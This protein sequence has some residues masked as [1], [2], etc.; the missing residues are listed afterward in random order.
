MERLRGG[1]GI[2]RGVEAAVWESSLRRK[3]G[4]C[5]DDGEREERSQDRHR[6]VGV[7]RLPTLLEE[8]C[9]VYVNE[10]QYGSSRRKEEE[11]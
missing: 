6:G 11:T 1:D 5:E 9:Q 3:S 4:D 7:E 2:T 8:D 10:M